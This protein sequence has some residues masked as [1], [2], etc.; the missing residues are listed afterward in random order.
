MTWQVLAPALGGDGK[1]GVLQSK[2]IVVNSSNNNNNNNNNSQTNS[3]H[4]I[5]LFTYW[6][7][8]LFHFLLSYFCPPATRVLQC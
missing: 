1:H 7:N 4:K 2:M 6:N 5:K 8:A 3:I